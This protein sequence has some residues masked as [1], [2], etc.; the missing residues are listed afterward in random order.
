L[1][2]DTIHKTSDAGAEGPSICKEQIFGR[3][4]LFPIAREGEL[5]SEFNP[6]NAKV[7]DEA[8]SIVPFGVGC[9]PTT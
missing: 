3:N 7:H 8:G 4:F 6:G 1:H 5:S 9:N 2:G